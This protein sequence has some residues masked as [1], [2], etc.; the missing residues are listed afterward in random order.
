MKSC[1]VV[2]MIFVCSSVF[3]AQS[4]KSRT[5]GEVKEWHLKSSHGEITFR[6]SARPNSIDGRT[7]L[8]LEPDDD[9]VPSTREEADLLAQVLGEM[10]SLGYDP[11]KLEMISTWLQNTEYRNGIQNAVAKSGTWKSCTGQKYCYQAETVA[12]HHLESV[13]AFKAFDS[14]LHSYGLVRKSVRIDDM[15]VGRGSDG[16][17]CSGLVVIALEKKE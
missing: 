16:V 5:L 8:S 1:V 6:L 3:G 14:A 9:A 13:D 2:W 10:P 11:R 15:G 7:A 12:D 17:S 4:S